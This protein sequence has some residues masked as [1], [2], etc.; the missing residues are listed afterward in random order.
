MVWSE[1]DMENLKVLWTDK[2]GLTYE[3]L[4]QALSVRNQHPGRSFT[5]KSIEKQIA[6][7]Y[8]QD[9]IYWLVEMKDVFKAYIYRTYLSSKERRNETLTILK[10][11][12]PYSTWT[13]DT[14]EQR[15]KRMEKISTLEGKRIL[16]AWKANVPLPDPL[17]GMSGLSG[18]MALTGIAGPAHLELESHTP[19]RSSERYPAESKDAFSYETGT[20]ESDE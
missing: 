7:T 18:N 14:I 5:P 11:R 17:R 10:A 3:E 1:D 13:I 19:Q 16:G 20:D 4:A 8:G 15:A 12:F 2:V 9:L 6:L